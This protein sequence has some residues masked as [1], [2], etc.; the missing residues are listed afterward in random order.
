[1]ERV[2]GPQTPYEVYCYDCHVTFAA[3]T[4]RC[5]H[6][7]R[8]LGRPSGAAPSAGP[9]ALEEMEAD[10]NPLRRAGGISLWVLI[11]VGAAVARMCGGGGG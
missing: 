3:G 1:M 10:A 6:C 8:R 5:I 7:G 11:A 4:P 2:E 9:Q